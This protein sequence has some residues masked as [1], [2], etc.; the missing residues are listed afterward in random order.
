MPSQVRQLTGVP[1][2]TKCADCGITATESVKLGPVQ[3]GINHPVYKETYSFYKSIKDNKLR[4]PR[5]ERENE[6]KG[7]FKAMDAFEKKNGTPA[8]KERMGFNGR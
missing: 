8:L 4:C 5:C 7:V 2:N 6:I 1:P 3:T